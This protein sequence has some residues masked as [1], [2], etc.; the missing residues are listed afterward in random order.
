MAISPSLFCWV[1]VMI[2]SN[3]E[4]IGRR[5]G[6]LVVDYQTDDHVT[7]KGAH[8]AKF[9]CKCDCGGE[10]DVL[11]YSLTSGR[12]IG[13]GCVQRERSK[14]KWKEVEFRKKMADAQRT[15]EKREILRQSMK[16]SWLRED[17]REARLAGCRKSESREKYRQTTLNHIDEIRERSITHGVW[18]RH[19]KL[20]RTI[21]NHWSWCYKENSKYYRIYGAVG[22]RF[23]DEWLD[24]EG[25]PNWQVIEDWAIA[26]GWDE[27]DGKVF[28]K[29][30][31]ANK[32]RVKEISPRTVRFVEDREN[33]NP[34]CRYKE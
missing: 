8:Y 21:Y 4:M 28:E 14:E 34:H 27:N 22:W 31:L 7:P 20:A 30:Y 10:C 19:P 29:D 3:E 13:C 23:C 15:P 1:T 2:V 26:N 25:K 33:R 12:Q 16:R 5:F 6:K 18:S 11:K 32:I 9:H 17:F 24:A